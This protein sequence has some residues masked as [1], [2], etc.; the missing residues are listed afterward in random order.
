MKPSFLDTMDIR[1]S[2][3]GNI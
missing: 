2:S 1:V 3:I